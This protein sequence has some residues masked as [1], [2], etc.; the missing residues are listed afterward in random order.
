LESPHRT[1][2]IPNGRKLWG[3]RGFFMSFLSFFIAWRY[4]RFPRKD[5]NISFMIR[6]CFLGIFIGT[7]ALMLTLIITNGFEKVIHEKMQGITSQVVIHAPGKQID[8]KSIKK[9]LEDE[10]GSRVTAAS[11]SS[12]KQVIIDHKKQQSVLFIKG[13]EPEN[14]GKVST[15]AKKIT[16][17]VDTNFEK[18]LTGNNIIVGYKTASRYNLTQGSKI[19][20]M[21]PEPGGRGKIYLQKKKVTVG[22]IFKIGLDEY[23]SNFAYCSLDLLHSMFKE[24]NK[25]AVDQISLSLNVGKK[26]LFHDRETKIINSLKRRLI[27][28]SV[29]SWKDLYPALVSS[30]KL[31]KYVMFFILALIT[32]VAC[33]NMISL[34]FMQIQQKRRDIAIFKAMGMSHKNLKRIFLTIGLSITFFASIFGLGLAACVGYFLERYPFI[35]LPDVYYVSYL[36]ARMEPEIFLV[37]F[38]CT[39]AIGFLAT[40]IPAQR[41]RKIKIVDVLRQ[42]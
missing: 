4:L 27:G 38:L 30:L 36:P 16:F 41:T 8:A 18:L 12:T 31:E 29:N 28:L 17:P 35:E 39:I 6:I 3:L 2:L 7:F 22:G 21:I 20:L 23:D 42:E 37:V 33:M 40:W 5:K 32:L 10:F 24:K 15:I 1:A 9:V 14:E 25:N 11:S 13:V 34:L 19:N 26:K